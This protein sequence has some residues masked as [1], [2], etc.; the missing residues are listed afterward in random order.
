[1][2]TD[3]FRAELRLDDINGIPLV[4]GIVG[5]FGLARPAINAVA[6]DHRG[7]EKNSRFIW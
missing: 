4:D 2:K 1:V 7:H 5:A 3:A 6:G